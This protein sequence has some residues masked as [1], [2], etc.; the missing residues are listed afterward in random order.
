MRFIDLT[1]TFTAKMPIYPGDAVPQLQQIAHIEKDKL[2]DHEVQTGMHV[3]THIDGPMH[4]IE[5]GRKLSEIPIE[6]FVGQGILIDTRGKSVIDETVVIAA[7]IPQGSIV[8]CLT[9]W[10]EKFGAAEYYT[11]FP[12][13]TRGCALALI[14]HG[15][16]IIGLDTPGPDDSPFPLHKLFLEKEIL[17]IENLTHLDALLGVEAFEIYALPAKFETDSAPARV[18]ARIVS[19]P[20]H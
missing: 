1:H 4:I 20:R 16:K 9:G 11:D 3:G 2:A 13:M 17:L 8:L 7:E 10:S 18:I 15:V 19:I 12:R 5:G 6:R 14:D